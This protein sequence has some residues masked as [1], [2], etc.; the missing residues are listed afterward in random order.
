MSM[1]DTDQVRS[2]LRSAA[3]AAGEAETFFDILIPV[4]DGRTK[5]PLMIGQLFG[6]DLIQHPDVAEG[7]MHIK[8]K[9]LEN[10]VPQSMIADLLETKRMLTE[11]LAKEGKTD[12][13]HGAS[14]AIS[15]SIIDEEIV[16]Y[17]SQ[18]V[19]GPKS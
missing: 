15:I 11:L 16:T 6:V 19:E 18:I 12:A 10:Y 4:D 1:I 3:S 9:P 17:Q 13:D 7:Q 5:G 8:R 2:A 14:L